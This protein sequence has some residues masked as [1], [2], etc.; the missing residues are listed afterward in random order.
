MKS[1]IFAGL[2]LVSSQQLYDNIRSEVNVF[3]K[4]NFEKQ[5]SKNRDKGISIVHFYKDECKL[6]QNSF[7]L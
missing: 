6:K 4:M 1:V 7:E 2:G 5:V 3:S